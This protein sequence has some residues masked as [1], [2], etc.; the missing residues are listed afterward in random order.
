VYLGAVRFVVAALAL[1]LLV[2]PSTAFAG[3]SSATPSALTSGATATADT[4]GYTVEPNEPNTHEPFNQQCGSPYN[5]GVAR[6]AWYTIQGAGGQ[7][8]VTTQ[9]SDFDTALFVYTGSLSGGVVACNDDRSDTDT[10][11]SVSFP[12]TPGTTYFIQVGRACNEVG[13]P[14]CADNPPSGTLSLTATA[15]STTTPGDADHDG[16]VTNALG[17]PDCNDANPAIHP[18]ATDIPHDGIDQDCSGKDAPYP[19]LR[20]TTS[21]SVGYGRAFTI[22]SSLK[23]TG[24]LPGSRIRLS[25]AS[26]HRGCRFSHRTVSVHSAR[27]VQLG[28][29]LKKARYKRGATITLQVSRPGYIGAHIRYTV[30]LHRLPT[31]TTRCTQ[32]GQTRPRTTCS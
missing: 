29:Y 18:G 23:V 11:S 20:V 17:G 10:T 32:P 12:S 7:V 1:L 30:R 4:T 15:L 24:A 3:D 26:R 13:P 6:T 9:G 21:V 5:V 19:R 31:R 14:K 27:A 8:T 28:R 16:Y 22:I 2:A 25:C